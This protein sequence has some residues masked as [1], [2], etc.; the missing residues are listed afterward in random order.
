MLTLDDV[1]FLL[2]TM[3]EDIEEIIE[4]QEAKQEAMYNRIES[5]LQGMQ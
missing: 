4:K 1:N 5:D 3:N 2:A